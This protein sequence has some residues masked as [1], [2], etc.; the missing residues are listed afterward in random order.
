MLTTTS[1]VVI[2]ER[3]SGENNKIIDILTEKSGI[4]S[5]YVRGGCKINGKNSASSQL[6]VYSKFCIEK[7][8]DK[9]ILNSSEVIKVFYDL[10]LDIEKISLASYF[11]ELLLYT[12]GSCEDTPE[13]ICR[14]LLNSLY[15]LSNGERSAKFLKSVFEMRLLSEIGLMPGLIGC[16]VCIK[17]TDDVMYFDLK[18]GKLFCKTC[19]VNKSS[20]DIAAVS[21]PVLSALRHIALSD[22]NRLFNFRMSEHCM[23]ELCDITQRYALTQLGRNFSTLE[24][25]NSLSKGAEL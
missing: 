25:Y 6:F 12:V 17:Y 19:C 10:R 20:T 14:L 23:T 7:S 18:N 13:D 5:A 1:G 16:A 3:L 24:Y 22:M 8:N 2:R 9:C 11:S 15:F 21:E 4:I